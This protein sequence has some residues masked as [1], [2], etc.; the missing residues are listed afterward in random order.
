MR[1]GALTA[2]RLTLPEDVCRAE[3]ELREQRAR[4][5]RVEPHPTRERLEQRLP[6][7]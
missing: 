5:D 4:V 3:P 7:V 2:R 1:A 6:D